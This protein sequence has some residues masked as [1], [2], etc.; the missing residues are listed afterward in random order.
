M[1]VSSP[2]M[3]MDLLIWLVNCKGHDKSGFSGQPANKA[4][5]G[6]GYCYHKLFFFHSLF[7]VFFFLFLD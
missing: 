7:F 5:T 2:A 4:A 3:V 6:D 1:M